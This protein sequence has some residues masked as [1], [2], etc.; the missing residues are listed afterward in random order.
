MTLKL[1]VGKTYISKPVTIV[2]PSNSGIFPFRGDSGESY[3]EHGKYALYGDGDPRDL[4][5][6]ATQLSPEPPT[7]RVLASGLTLREHFAGLALQS[8]GTWSPV[9]HEYSKTLNDD[10][11]LI[12]RAR[13][14]VSQAD[15]LIAALEGRS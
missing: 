2:G 15:A 9:P 14:A 10:E 4:F 1:E 7:E 6:E 8:I 12:A 13:W 11:T 5:S 3:D